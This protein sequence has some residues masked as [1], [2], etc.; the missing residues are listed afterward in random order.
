MEAVP[1]ESEEPTTSEE[2]VISEEP[3]VS[4]NPA[5][6]EEPTVSENPVASEEPTASEKPVVSENPTIS[7]E[8]ATSEN[9]VTSQN[10]A[11]PVVTTDTTGNP[12]TGRPGSTS[13]NTT[14]APRVQA[15]EEPQIMSI[16]PG[17]KMYLEAGVPYWLDEGLWRVKGDNTLYRGGQKIRVVVSGEYEFVKE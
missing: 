5:A 1:V 4:E 13:Q 6:S 16:R 11:N 17:E 12:L 8:P 7:K 15:S 2:P 9:S 14:S 10:P 3:T